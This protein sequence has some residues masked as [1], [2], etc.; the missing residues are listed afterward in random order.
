MWIVIKRILRHLGMPTAAPAIA[1][2]CQTQARALQTQ[3]SAG[4]HPALGLQW[5]QTKTSTFQTL[6]INSAHEYRRRGLA[7]VPRNRVALSAGSLWSHGDAVAV[8]S[9]D[10]G[11]KT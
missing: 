9:G 8:S 10:G 7:G 4:S 5:G 6:R 1:G 3:A 11:G 2:A